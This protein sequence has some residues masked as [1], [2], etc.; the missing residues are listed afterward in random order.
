MHNKISWLT[1]S[2]FLM[3]FMPFMA[4]ADERVYTLDANLRTI[5]RHFIDEISSEEKINL[6]PVL[7]AVKK[8]RLHG[9]ID[10]WPKDRTYRFSVFLLETYPVYIGK[11]GIVNIQIVDAVKTTTVWEVNGKAVV[12]TRVD[13]VLNRRGFPLRW[14]NKIRDGVVAEIE[15]KILDFEE[16]K[17]RELARND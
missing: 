11:L 13:V 17:L 7:D 8:P 5:A 6:I 16:E 14:V 1:I 15:N 10:F 4:N 2:V 3:L 12:K 9:K